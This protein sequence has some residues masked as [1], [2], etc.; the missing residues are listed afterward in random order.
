MAT[1]LEK[2][3]GLIGALLATPADQLDADGADIAE[4]LQI[5]D[6]LGIDVVAFIRPKSP[7]EAD[8]LVDKLICLLLALRGDDL[9]PFDPERYGELLAGEPEPEAPA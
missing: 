2:V 6:G 9:P 3:D 5:A 4:L 7:A 1:T 8:V